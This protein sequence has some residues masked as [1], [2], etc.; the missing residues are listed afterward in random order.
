MAAACEQKNVLLF[1]PCS[2]KLIRSVEKAH[3]DGV[4]CVRFLDNRSFATCSDDTTVALWDTRFLRGRVRTLRGHTNWVKNIEFSRRENCLVTSGLDGAIFLWDINKYSETGENHRNIFRTNGLMRM[5]ISSL[6]DR[7]VI[8]TM[9]GYIIV[10]HD[11]SLEHLEQD[12]KDFKPNMYRLLQMSGGQAISQAANFTP[13]FHADRNRVEFISDFAPGNEAEFISSLKIHPHGWVAVTRNVSADE[14]TEWC[15]VH[16]IHAPNSKEEDDEVLPTKPEFMKDKEEE[17]KTSTPPPE[18]AAPSS[19]RSRARNVVGLSRL[20]EFLYDNENLAN[21]RREGGSRS[22]PRIVLE[23]GPRNSNVD[24]VVSIQRSE[25]EEDPEPEPEENRREAS[26]AITIREVLDS[27]GRPSVRIRSD[28][29]ANLN[30]A[31]VQEMIRR[32]TARAESENE[33]NEDNDRRMP[34]AQPNERLEQR[35]IWLVS[36]GRRGAGSNYVYFGTPG[37]HRRQMVRHIM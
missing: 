17:E 11:L 1:D 21:Q 32:R 36:P 28:E 18:E 7:M 5:C 29:I 30:R 31:L 19:S 20:A 4:N 8:T 22:V 35:G 10:I 33:T 34:H 37:D 16:D 15:C 23:P 24:A 27:S 6:S 26:G 3:D 9:N 25:E 13:L 14:E 12:L 2:R